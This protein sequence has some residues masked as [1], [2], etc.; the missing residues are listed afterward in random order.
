VKYRYRPNVSLVVVAIILAVA[1]L[2]KG[3]PLKVFAIVFGVIGVVGIADYF[4]WKILHRT[5]ITK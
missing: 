5:K 4:S 3:A 2:A 1:L